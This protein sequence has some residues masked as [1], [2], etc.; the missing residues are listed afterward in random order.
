MSRGSSAFVGYNVVTDF[1][2]DGIRVSG[3]RTT[4]TVYRNSIRYLHTAETPDDRCPGHLSCATGII[5]LRNPL[6]II[7]ANVIRSGPGPGWT[8]PALDGG[9]YLFVGD[10]SVVAGN[11]IH[12]TQF[13]IE[14]LVAIWYEVHRAI[15]RGNVVTAGPPGSIGLYIEDDRRTPT[16]G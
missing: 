15:V 9:M 11:M 16:T 6:V 12:R 4:A 8:T 2:L 14:T 10:G 5:A 7:R 13:G 3:A 1:R